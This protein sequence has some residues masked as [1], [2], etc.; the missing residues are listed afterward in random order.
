VTVL[1]ATKE[2]NYAELVAKQVAECFDDPLRFVKLVFEWGE[3][4][5]EGCT[6]PDEWQA[7]LL[8]RIGDWV[9]KGG[10]IAEALQVAIASGH[11]IGK[12]AETAWII[13]WAMATRKDLNGVV[14]ANTKQQLETKTWR[15]LA[16]W[17]NRSI[18]KSMFEWTATKF[19]HVSA[20]ETWYVS[21][22]P[23]SEKNSEAFA[24]LHGEHVIIIYDEASSIPD[25]IWEVS[26]GAMTTP[27]AMW[28]VFGNPTRNT[29][30][31]RE[32]FGKNKHR[33]MTR[34]IDSRLCKMT[35]KRKL[36]QWVEDYGE[37]SDFVKIRVRGTF[38]S[39]SSMQFIPGDLV[40]D[41]QAR[42]AKCY[43]EEPL[44]LGVDV[45]RF[46]DDQSVICYRR[47]RDARTIE[48]GKYRGLDT[49][50]L[51]ARV[52]EAVH[53]HQVD[54]VFVDG[55][56]VGGGVVDRLRQLHVAVIEV[57][58]GSKA[59]DTR[60]QNKRAEMWGNMREWLPGGAL[61]KD[62]ELIDDLIGVEYGF[63]PTN[64]ILLEKKETMKKR[65]LASP[66]LGDALALTFAYPVAP[67]GMDKHRGNMAEKRR[68]YNP[69]DRKR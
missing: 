22:V 66:D 24:G 20:P 31:F 49:M 47:G 3:D 1:V 63:T 7:E 44:I 37:D 8:T 4:D 34:Q 23:W 57:N 68:N 33:W 5:L 13:L 53:T 67:K 48:W 69:Y 35:D 29:G 10:T 56:G 39:A 45:A 27:G 40:D 12:G 19:Y 18:I 55:G 28:F 14:T 36:A 16:L 17:H 52:S 59:E 61:P 51:A 21:A 38:P 58:F 15:E 46:G 41:A 50:Q 9:K 54:T 26:E 6:G 32:C 25:S 30:R 62:R 65:G 64:K 43:L 42:D 60:Y 11:G 2:I